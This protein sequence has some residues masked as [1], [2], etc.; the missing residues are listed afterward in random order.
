[1]GGAA[2]GGNVT[3]AAEFNVHT[4]PHAAKVVFEA[5]VPL[6]MCGL[7]VTNRAWFSEAELA[8]VGAFGTPAARFFAESLRTPLRAS[9]LGT[10]R[11]HDVTAVLFVS[12]PELFTGR[13]AGVRVETR[14]ALTLGKTVTDLWSDRKFPDQNA[15]VVLD[16]DRPAFVRRVTE[17]ICSLRA[18]EN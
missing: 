5:G 16:V 11:L 6:T 2:V 14:S 15:F 17:L 4:D 8:Q 3:P 12:D 9:G 7:D 13:M 10:V 18:V 1:M